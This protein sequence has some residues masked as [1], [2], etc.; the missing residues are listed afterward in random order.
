MSQQV[1]PTITNGKLGVGNFGVAV[2]PDGTTNSL[3]I[4][5]T[6]D[7][8]H[9]KATDFDDLVL[10][11]LSFNSPKGTKYSLSFDDDGALLINGV[12]YT[13]PTNQGNETIKGNK[14]YEGKTKLSGGLQLTSPNGTVFNVTVDDD[15]KLTTEKGGK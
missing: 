2:M 4:L 3:R 15:G 9:F 1:R 6:P 12:K 8:F 5:I 10:P 11:N 14:T 13:E 7:G